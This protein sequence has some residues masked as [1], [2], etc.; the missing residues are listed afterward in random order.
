VFDIIGWAALVMMLV[1]LLALAVF[2]WHFFR[3]DIQLDDP[4]GSIG[5]QIF[6]RRKAKR[7]EDWLKQ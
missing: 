5:W 2:A 7:P 3:G 6:S 4:G 1:V